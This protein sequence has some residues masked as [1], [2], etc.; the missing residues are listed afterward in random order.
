MIENIS[1][2]QNSNSPFEYAILLEG[3]VSLPAYQQIEMPA[4]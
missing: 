4:L 2:L 3:E 1:V